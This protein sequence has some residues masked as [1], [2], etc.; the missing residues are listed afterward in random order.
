MQGSDESPGDVGGGVGRCELDKLEGLLRP[1]VVVRQD[2]PGIG[3]VVEYADC[4]GS[5]REMLVIER[6]ATQRH[7]TRIRRQQLACIAEGLDV[8]GLP[9]ADLGKKGVLVSPLLAFGVRV[10]DI[11]NLDINPRI[12]GDGYDR[13][14]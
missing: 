10:E 2:G 5:Q 1:G 7:F 14:A 12:I 11:E 3:R 9:V 13:V 6:L 8:G 4:F